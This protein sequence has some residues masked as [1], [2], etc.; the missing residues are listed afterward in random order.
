MTLYRESAT[1]LD[2]AVA[3]NEEAQR[4]LARL[5]RREHELGVLFS[6]A[7]ELAAIQDSDLLLK[8]IVQRAHQMMGGD[9]SYL[10]EY[11]P[12]SKE[13]FVRTTVGS[14][15]A[16]FR[17][18]RV[19]PGKGL[20]SLVVE[21]RVGGAVRR[22]TDFETE[23]HVAE[24]DAAVDSEG[25]VS[26][27]GVPM[28]A[29]D[30]VLGVLFVATRQERV[31]SAE[32]LALMTALA[33]HASVVLQT[34]RTLRDLRLAQQESRAAIESLREHVVQ[35]DRAHAVHRNLVEA[36]LEGG[37]FSTVA[38]TL[39][40][41]LARPILVVDDTGR[42]LAQAGR[43][44]SRQR[45]E[46][47]NEVLPALES[48]RVSG[49]FVQLQGHHHITGA[50]AMA[51]GERHFGAI[52]LGEGEFGLEDVDVRTVERAAQV[53]ALLVLSQEAVAQAEHKEQSEL[54]ADLLSAGQQRQAVLDRA[55]RR[56]MD[57]V[58]FTSLL[59]LSVPSE[60][61][62]EAA[63]ATAAAAGGPALVGEYRGLVVVLS[64]GSLT[65]RAEHIRRA[66]GKRLGRQ[67]LGVTPPEGD[68]G[69]G[70]EAARRTVR[71]LEALGVR[72]TLAH[73]E[74]YLPYAAI[75]ETSAAEMERFLDGCVGQI[76]RYDTERGTELLQTVRTYVTHE[77]SP[78]KTA[79]AMNYHVNTILQRLERLDRL[80]GAGWREGERYFRMSLAVRLDELREQ[81]QAQERGSGSGM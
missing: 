1:A 34:A 50:A 4:E 36:V 17:S 61:R 51:A 78:T 54:V 27:A 19:P 21:Q 62:S 45:P 80:L 43:D 58:D 73:S 49:T 33:N 16:D 44:S 42:S 32:D 66:V 35:R 60:S 69:S 18:L 29:D 15:S 13:L 67:V 24:I 70:F 56:G 12:S 64:D 2:L 75:F 71:L 37:G 3:H 63:R 22:Y 30:E 26:M 11:D 40:S 55:R 25:I 59:V 28:L 9:L 41:E 53:G 65:G 74:D 76:R 23:R 5:R 79:R 52:L 8:R 31:F 48:S 7:G 39:A 14:V 38:E 72:A 10:S 6:S 47:E 20:A 77:A 68:I 46:W 57:V 81:V